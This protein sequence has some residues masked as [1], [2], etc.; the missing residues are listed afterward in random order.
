MPGGWIETMFTQSIM[1]ILSQIQAEILSSLP[2]RVVEVQPKGSFREPFALRDEVVLVISGLF[3]LYRE[4]GPGRRQIVALRY[5][6]EGIIPP[7]LPA[8]FGLQALIPSR[9]FVVSLEDFEDRIGSRPEFRD[10]IR[11][12]SERHMAIGYEWLVNNSQNETIGRVAHLL[13]ETA[14]RATAGEKGPSV[15]IP[16]TQGQIADITG[17]TGV[18]VSRV[19]AELE[20]QGLIQ[21]TGRLIQFLDWNGLQQIGRFNPGYL[22]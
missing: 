13:C 6:N 2:G 3:G 12:R 14:Y 21:R 1:P 18:N 22:Q 11:R 5:P 7:E 20:G 17:Q 9:V 8:A 16:F 19:F 10:A 4:C 15:L